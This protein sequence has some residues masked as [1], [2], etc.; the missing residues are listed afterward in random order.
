MKIKKLNLNIKIVKQTAIEIMEIHNEV[1]NYKNE[2]SE[3][4]KS[5]YLLNLLK[6]ATIR[7]VEN[8]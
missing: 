5:C 3:I 6:I 1:I 4:M 7:K 2:C 8:C